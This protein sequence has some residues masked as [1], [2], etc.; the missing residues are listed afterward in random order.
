MALI[1]IYVLLI[2]II[3][4]LIIIV[5]LVPLLLIGLNTNTNNKTIE[6]VSITYRDY[7]RNIVM[8]HIRDRGIFDIIIKDTNRYYDI[9]VLTYK[10][11]MKHYPITDPKISVTLKINGKYIVIYGVLYTNDDSIYLNIPFNGKI[12]ITYDIEV[13]IILNDL[14]N[15]NCCTSSPC[16]I[17]PDMKEEMS[18][19]DPKQCKHAKK[20]KRKHKKSS[21]EINVVYNPHNKYNRPIT[22]QSVPEIKPMPLKNVINPKPGPVELFNDESDPI[23]SYTD[24]YLSVGA[25]LCRDL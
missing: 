20:K 4:I 18:I 16:D 14:T 9:S 17:C 10:L 2:I 6:S 7:K 23:E 15:I 1:V 25:T 19:E 13:Y 8:N 12:S 24:Y 21:S 11:P 22:V 3:I 5:V